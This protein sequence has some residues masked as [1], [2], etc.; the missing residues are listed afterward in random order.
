MAAI[1]EAIE[2]LTDPAARR[3]VIE[4]AAD[5]YEVGPRRGKGAAGSSGGGDGSAMPESADHGGETTEF[6]DFSE[7]YN[8]AG[9]TTDRERILVAGYWLQQQQGEQN[10]H[11]DNIND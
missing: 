7:L 5:R 1:S 2:S 11:A 8:A 10:L 9:P 4:W 3:R 6:R